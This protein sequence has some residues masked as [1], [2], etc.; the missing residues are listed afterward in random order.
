MKR[1]SKKR[2]QGSVLVMTLVTCAVIAT[3]L[4]SYLAFISVRY[5][6]TVRS[7]G[8][9][10]AIPVL[11]A[12]VEEAF[13]H[14]NNDATP[15]ANGWTADV[16]GGQPVHT[17]NRNFADGSYYTAYIYTN[18]AFTN[19]IIHSTGFVPA[20]L[21]RGYINR[22]VRVT[23]TRLKM[24]PY[25]IAANGKVD[26]GGNRCLFDQQKWPGHQWRHRD[27]FRGLTG[28]HPGG[29][30]RLWDGHYWP[31]WHRG[32]QQRHRRRRNLDCRSY[33]H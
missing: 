3:V 13:T 23:T 14:L 30:P 8:W 33:C 9:N 19:P 29:R 20:P 11:E 10:A 32:H 17:K 21:R 7:M 24:F 18:A 2:E 22:T 6:L 16:V 12:G 1:L 27:Q 26:L 5:N 25:A 28:T 15:T 31:T 4:T